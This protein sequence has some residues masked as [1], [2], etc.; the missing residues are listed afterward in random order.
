[1]EKNP[2]EHEEETDREETVAYVDPDSM[3]M[4]GM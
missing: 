3:H 1:M 2:E 4:S